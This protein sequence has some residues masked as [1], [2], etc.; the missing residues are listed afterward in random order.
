[1][2]ATVYFCTLEALT[3]VAKY[4]EA[5]AATVTI[6]H[7]DGALRFSVSDN[8]HGF[9]PA[10]TMFGTGLQGIEDRLAALGGEFSITTAVGEGTTIDGR[11]PVE[12]AFG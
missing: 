5:S 4:A 3:N 7:A 11:L 1:V 2:E 9:D 6:E 12:R 8:G 10:E